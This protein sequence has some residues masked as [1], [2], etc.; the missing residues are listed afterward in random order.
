MFCK[1]RSVC[2][3]SLVRVL[4]DLGA[5][6]NPWHKYTSR[7]H[8]PVHPS[9][10]GIHSSCLPRT[11]LGTVDGAGSC[12]HATDNL[13]FE[14]VREQGKHVHT[15]RTYV[16]VKQLKWRKSIVVVALKILL[17]IPRDREII[18]WVVLRTDAQLALFISCLR[19]PR[20]TSH[21]RYRRRKIV[22]AGEV[23][24]TRHDEQ[25]KAIAIPCTHA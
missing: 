20:P 9:W 19:S 10:C 17:K 4:N 15:V 3:R 2:R 7:N 14:F 6:Q 23:S 22:L 11:S 18:L 16:D 5:G 12:V 8:V 24:P 25:L 13:S 21:K 1:Q